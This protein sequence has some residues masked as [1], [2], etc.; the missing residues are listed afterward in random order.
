MLRLCIHDSCLWF[1]NIIKYNHCMVNYSQTL[2]IRHS[3]IDWCSQIALLTL[4]TIGIGCSG[5]GYFRHHGG[6]FAGFQVP[7]RLLTSGQNRNTQLIKFSINYLYSGIWV[8]HLSIRILGKDDQVPGQA[9]TTHAKGSQLNDLIHP[10]S[11]TSTMHKFQKTSKYTVN[12]WTNWTMCWCWVTKVNGRPLFSIVVLI[13]VGCISL[14]Q[15]ICFN[16]SRLDG[17]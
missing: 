2:A 12:H 7:S 11:S 15:N 1:V 16:L 9:C 8:Y 5:I 4:F 10:I 14:S 6:D 17:G 3:I 13:C